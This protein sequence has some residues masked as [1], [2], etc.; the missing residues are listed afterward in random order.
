MYTNKVSRK[1][2]PLLARIAILLYLELYHLT[3][4][5]GYKEVKLKAI[6]KKLGLKRMPS[7]KIYLQ[8]EK[9][10]SFNSS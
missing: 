8:I 2:H 1:G 3:P 6:Y 4:E 9:E 5:R 7:S 10:A